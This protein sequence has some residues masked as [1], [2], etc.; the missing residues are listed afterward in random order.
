VSTLLPV[1]HQEVQL[2][3][4]FVFHL[5][6]PCNRLFVHSLTEHRRTT[7]TWMPNA[8]SDVFLF[9]SKNQPGS[10]IRNASSLQHF[11]GDETAA[12]KYPHPLHVPAQ[13]TVLWSISWEGFTTFS[14]AQKSETPSYKA[15]VPDLATPFHWRASGITLQLSGRHRLRTEC[16]RGCS[17]RLSCFF[18][19]GGV[20]FCLP[21]TKITED[22]TGGF[23]SL[24]K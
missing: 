22:P 14:L 12:S 3:R 20:V 13:G 8:I 16:R 6:D 7:V 23:V 1:C 11:V 15:R 24:Q 21:G 9:F 17:L 18:F 4:L 2:R 5:S 10:E 19:L